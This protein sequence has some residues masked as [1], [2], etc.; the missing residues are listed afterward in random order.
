[1][2]RHLIKLDSTVLVKRCLWCISTAQCCLRYIL[3]DWK[4]SIFGIIFLKGGDAFGHVVSLGHLLNGKGWVN[5]WHA[6]DIGSWI[7]ERFW[8]RSSNHCIFLYFGDG[9]FVIHIV[10]LNLHW[11]IC[12][13]NIT[14]LRSTNILLRSS[15]RLTCVLSNHKIFARAKLGVIELD[16]VNMANTDINLPILCLVSEVF[17]GALELKV[18]NCSFGCWVKCNLTYTVS[19]LILGD[20]V[21]DGGKSGV[22]RMTFDRLTLL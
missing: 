17:G 21:L 3:F 4:C 1:M 18:V 6:D 5:F 14:L 12:H 22:R 15:E 7:L 20:G 2:P 11:V 8:K 16:G 19:R 10:L 13:F 9:V